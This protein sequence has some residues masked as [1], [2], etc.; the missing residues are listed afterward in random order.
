MSCISQG[1]ST[2]CAQQQCSGGLEC[3]LLA[4]K[5]DVQSVQ[6]DADGKAI[7]IVMVGTAVFYNF[8]F[9]DESAEFKEAL[10]VTDCTIAVD[11][12]VDMIWSCRNHEDRNS[13][14]NL[15]GCCCGLVAIHFENTGKGWIWGYNEKQRVKLR[16][17]DSVS[18]K[19]ISDPNTETLL[20]GA[21]AREK[22]IEWTA[23]KV[24]IPL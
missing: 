12:T 16:T 5:D 9:K 24:G 18:G 19:A 13:I 21:N 10:S 15:A 4:N 6:L 8:D 14:M 2:N 7:G 3:L 20:L 11:Q 22:A 1:R 23:G 17:N